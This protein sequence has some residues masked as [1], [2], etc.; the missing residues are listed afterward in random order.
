MLLIS[1]RTASTAMM[2]VFPLLLCSYLPFSLAR[3]GVQSEEREDPLDL[4]LTYGEAVNEVSFFHVCSTLYCM[5]F[6]TNPSYSSAF[7]FVILRFELFIQIT[8]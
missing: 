1:S 7:P 2:K 5:Y 8:I 6:E 4:N 3:L